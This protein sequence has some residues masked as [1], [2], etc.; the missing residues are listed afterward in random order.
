VSRRVLVTG[1]TGFI[2]AALVARLSAAGEEVHA[3]SRTAADTAGAR[4]STLDLADAA[5]VQQAMERIAPEVVFHLAG[6]VTGA[7]QI[8]EVLPS[9]HANLMSTVHLLTAAHRTGCRRLVLAGSMEEPADSQQAPPSPYA[10]A[11]QASG[12]YL[13]L[14]RDL[15]SLETVHLRIFMVYGPGQLDLRKVIPHAT[16]S[17][18]RGRAPE[19]ASGRRR[20][21]WVYRDDVVEALVAAGVA[22]QLPARPIDVGTGM[23]TSV[24]E[25]V[26]HLHARLGG[27]APRF[28]AQPDRPL[29]SEPVADT[30]LA[31]EALGWQAT[32]GLREGLD[33]TAEWYAAALADGRLG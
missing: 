24:R 31:R 20:L 10:A 17:L 1:A 9:V 27:P 15:Y 28:G 22:P 29:E 5:A 3:V 30:A 4:W 2:G 16:L 11:K 7:R 8:D 18:L 14:F 13:R 19:L 23:R 12:I 26:E 6:R 32:T 25:A 33:R 21:D